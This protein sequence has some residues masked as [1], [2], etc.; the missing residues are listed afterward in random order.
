MNY[1]SK[2]INE[3]KAGK[4]KGY[5]VANIHVDQEAGYFPVFHVVILSLSEIYAPEY[6]HAQ[7]LLK[8]QTAIA[9]VMLY[10]NASRHDLIDLLDSYE[11]ELKTIA[12]AIVEKIDTGRYIYRSN[13]LDIWPDGAGLEIWE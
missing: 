8:Y 2:N 4:E 1:H 9:D 3:K 11:S 12:A 6:K 5:G 13:L 10:I 7:R